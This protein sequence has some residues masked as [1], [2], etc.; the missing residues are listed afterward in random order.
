MATTS[1]CPNILEDIAT[2]SQ[3][4]SNILDNIASTSQRSNILGNVTMTSQRSNITQNRRYKRRSR[5]YKT[6]QMMYQIIYKAL[7]EKGMENTYKP[8]DYLNF[9][10]LGNRELPNRDPDNVSSGSQTETNDLWKVLETLKLQWVLTNLITHG[11]K[12][13]LGHMDRYM[14][15]YRM[16][17]LAKH[18]GII[19]GC[20][21]YPESVE[22]V[23]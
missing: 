13:I 15:G 19:E 8:Q 4:P 16:S 20:F 11:L 7:E 18:L 14:H 3:H 21:M 1:Q 6:M 17:L 12:I 2:T 10:C 5:T 23:R 9:F 22:C